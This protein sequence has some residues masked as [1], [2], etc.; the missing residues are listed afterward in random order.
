MKILL[1]DRN[2]DFL[3]G[4]E[5]L[6]TADRH[7]V[8]T[9]FDGTQVLT[10]AAV[11]RFDLVLMNERQPRV[12]SREIVRYLNEEK[13]PVVILSE[14]GETVMDKFAGMV[15]EGVLC[16]PFEPQEMRNVLA[17]AEGLPRDERRAQERSE[18]RQGEEG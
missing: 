17:Q 16:F 3:S 9:A 1:A 10:K 5:K 15:T 2:R 6:L 11:T 18:E 8:V 7:E 13:I 12:D 4:Y 14:E